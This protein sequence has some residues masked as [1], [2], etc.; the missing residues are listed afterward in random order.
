MRVSLLSLILTIT[1]VA[2]AHAE[3]HSSTPAQN[4]VLVAAPEQVTI[5]FT[6]TLEVPFSVFKVYALDA[7]VDLTNDKVFLKLNGL[8]SQLIPDALDARDDEDAPERVDAGVISTQNTTDTV[9]LALK[10][11]LAPG[12]YVVMWRVLASDTHTSQGHTLFI[13]QP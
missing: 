5:T 1:S 2:F 10:D 6:E 12:A 4:E 9:T 8:A 13:I 3:Y 7:D 11:D